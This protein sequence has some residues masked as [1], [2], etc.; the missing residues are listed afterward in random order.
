MNASSR[1]AGSGVRKPPRA[2]PWVRESRDGA[3]WLLREGVDPGALRGAVVAPAGGAASPLGRGGFHYDHPALGP[4]RVK[5]HRRGGLFGML[6]PE[7][8]LNEGAA[9]RELEVELILPHWDLPTQET[10]A[11]R[12]Q[13]ASP[14]LTSV[15]RYFPAE[16]TLAELRAAG[17]A[18]AEMETAAETLAHALFLAGIHHR[19]FHAGNLLWND[20][21]KSLRLIDLS[22]ARSG[23]EARVNN[24]VDRMLRR[25]AKPPRAYRIRG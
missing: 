16:I 9:R 17:R 24:S 5:F 25:L 6:F 10:L 3:L 15:Q 14:R 1:G 2:F 20:H 11:F 22:S 19:D 8:G 21:R 13:R 18:T 23:R 7:W 4:L 12:I